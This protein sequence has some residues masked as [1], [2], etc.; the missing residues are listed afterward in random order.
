[1]TDGEVLL[2]LLRRACDAAG[3][4]VR[5]MPPAE[6]RR[7]VGAGAGGDTTMEVDRAAEDAAVA[8]LAAGGMPFRLVSEEAGEREVGGGG[9]PWIVLDPIDG[10]LNASRGLPAFA[11]SIALAEGPAMRDVTLGVIRDH[12]TGE[13]WIAR[14]GG[15]ATVDGRPV[16][17]DG[18]PSSLEL[19]LIEGA[20]PD[21][22]GPAAAG[23]AGRDVKRIRALGSLAL[24]LCHAAAGRGDGMVALA[25]GRSID[26]A[27]AQLVAREA[28]LL[29][30][31][32]RA[33]DT[34]GMTLRLDAR[35]HVVGARDAATLELLAG[36]IPPAP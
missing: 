30:G 17:A 3:A 34:P 19:V 12:G 33:E 24:S 31:L 32:P 35:F 15:G 25:P 28:G 13:E 11:T 16:V 21:R 1:L 9:G 26:I 14:A 10:S 5:D 22:I 7:P 23:L 27:A 20:Y 4:A 18:D 2:A 29:V 8:A 6:R 36:L